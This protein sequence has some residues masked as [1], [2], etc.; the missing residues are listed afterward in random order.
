MKIERNKLVPASGEW[1]LTLGV[2]GS[3]RR[4][5]RRR[6]RANGSGKDDIVNYPYDVAKGHERVL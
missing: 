1:P 4:V 2:S 6:E 5:E 3:S